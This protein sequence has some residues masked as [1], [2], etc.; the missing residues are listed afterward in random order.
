MNEKKLKRILSLDGGGIRGI[1]TGQILVALEDK[2]NKKYFEIKKEHPKRQIRLG[3]YFDMMS[4]T[5][6]GGILTC[7]LLCPDEKDPNYPKFSAKDAVELYEKNAKTIFRPTFSGRLPGFLSGIGGSKYGRKTMEDLLKSYFGNRMLSELL[8][9]CLITS[10]DIQQRRAVFFTQHDAREKDNANFP[11]WQVARSTSAA[12][13]YFPPAQAEAKDALLLNTIDGGLFANNPT[14]CAMIEALKVFSIDKSNMIG[15]DDLFIVSIGTGEIKKAYTYTD[16]VKWG[17]LR[18]ITPIIDIM[19]T[20][21][22][23]TVHYQLNKLYKTMGHAKSYYRI[24]PELGEASPEM[25]VSTENNVFNLKQAGLAT[26]LK[27]DEE[28]EEI[29]RQLIENSY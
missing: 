20:G 8:K 13:S 10:Y 5:S 14:M 29:A 21:V 23:E 12:P 9:P 3:E 18:W 7:I 2:L 11:I 16:A 27:Y 24:M 22:S 4:G 28:L 15:P 26:A 1:L 17:I 19:M 25:D 6:T